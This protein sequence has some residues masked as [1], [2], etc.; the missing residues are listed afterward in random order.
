M[1]TQ[2]YKSHSRYVPMYHFVLLIIIILILAG[3]VWNFY[4][5]YDAHAGRL[6]AAL[7][8]ALDIV[9]IFYYIYVR[10]FALGAQD[11]VIRAEENLRH[12]IL[13]GKP[14]DSRLRLGQI[15]ALRFAGDA[16]FVALAKRA[17]EENLRSS[18]IKQAIQE[19]RPDNIRI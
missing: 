13:A 4:R 17:A 2:S 12:F 5:A 1:S 7:I 15:I 14:L 16:E 3:S 6:S 9:A 11:R 18:D 8:F 10:G 19:W